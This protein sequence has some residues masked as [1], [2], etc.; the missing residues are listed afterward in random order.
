MDFEGP[1]D[2]EQ[3]TI[4]LI[5]R[6]RLDPQG[7][8]ALQGEGLASGVSS[9]PKQ[10]LAA[11]AQLDA[12][13]QAHSDDMIAR[14]YFAHTNLDGESPF[15]RMAEAGYDRYFTAGENLAWAGGFRDPETAAQI[16]RHVSGLWG[17]DGHQRNTMNGSFS[18][19][20]VGFASGSMSLN[21]RF[22]SNASTLTEKFGDRGVAYL[23]GVVIDDA[24]GDVFY[25]V[26]EGQGDVRITAWND[27]G[28]FATS[29]WDAGGYSLALD[30]GVYTVVFE[31]GELDGVVTRTIE[32]GRDNV[33]LDVVEDRDVEAVGSDGDAPVVGPAP[34]DPVTEDP[35]T[36]D[37][38]PNAPAEE[39]DPLAFA[40]PPDEEDEAEDAR[41]RA[42][43]AT[44]RPTT[45]LKRIKLRRRRAPRR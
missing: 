32:I 15:D 17:S 21:D 34:D 3:L 26:G 24:D 4:E 13:A 35:V 45:L 39:D 18:E 29:T 44:R 1:S 36:E 28:A 10:P 41:R 12:A 25:D 16:E 27:E 20:G 2:L 14:N 31:G 9:A 40:P 43:R 5:N 23:T 42:D 22:F 33:K 38:A 8:V 6:A 30:P 11:V 37:P 19:I 7:E